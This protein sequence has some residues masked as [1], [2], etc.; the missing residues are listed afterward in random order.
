MLTCPAF[1]WLAGMDDRLPL[2]LTAC[3]TYAPPVEL[4]ERKGLGHP[5][6]LCDELAESLA[7][8]LATMLLAATGAVQHFKVDKGLLV[9]GA[10]KVGFGG[11]RRLQPAHVILAGRADLLRW[12]IDL[13]EIHDGLCD[14]I[15]R[16]VPD[17][18]ADTFQFEFRLHPPSRELA[19]L[20]AP[21]GEIPLAN[22]TSFA[23]VSL[24]RSLLE[25]VTLS[26]ERHLGS[27]TVRR[28]LPIGP[29]IKVM[30]RRDGNDVSLT[31]A[32]A[33]LAERLGNP[34]RIRRSGRCRRAGGP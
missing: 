21:E 25:E 29:D 31:V 33:L 18:Q 30:G 5:D 8:R 13:D 12:S 7:R 14:D 34:C 3:E 4:V 17:A 19:A 15:A 6:T 22:D 28:Q 1:A 16:L 11:G 10:V 32:V 20:T 27:P 24:P 26:V 23:T 9:A 2:R